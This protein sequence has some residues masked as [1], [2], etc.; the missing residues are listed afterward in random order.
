M[1]DKIKW[2][3]LGSANI[4][5]QKVIPAMQQSERCEVTALASR[6]LRKAQR[7]ANELGIPRAY[8]SYDELLADPDI[9]A[10]YNPLPNHLHVPWTIK[11]AEAGK[12]VL[13]EKP[14]ALTAEEARQL[15]AVR[16]RTGKKIEEAFMVRTHP[17]WIKV[18]E[19]IEAGRIGEVR[20]IGGHFSYNNPDP[21]NIRNMADIGGGGL[22]DI[23]CYLIFFSRLIFKAEPGRVIGLIK[24]DAATRTDVLTSALLD[25]PQG[26]AA[27]T[28]GTRMTPYQRIQIVG[29]TGRIEVEIPVNTPPDQRCKIMIDDGSDLFGAGVETLEFQI[30][31]QYTVQA[32]HFARS[33]REDQPPVNRL[34]DSIRNMS[35]IDAIFRSADSGAWEV[36]EG[37]T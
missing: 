36:P 37:L 10:V 3:V 27:F 28:C 20:S 2:G 19:L 7:F 8:G 6:D 15:L 14:I 1:T 26:Q 35:V 13:C 21:Q 32:D 24:K 30:C 34:E 16:D 4:A 5:V 33:I 11:A 17:Q 25:F 9:D 12:H 23:G 18:R 22:M 29:T 31:D